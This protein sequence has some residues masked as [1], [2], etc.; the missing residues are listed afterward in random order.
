MLFN[1]LQFLIFFIVVTPAYYLLSSQR[2]RVWLLLIASC[3]F[4]MSFVPKYILILGFTIIIDYLAGLQ[5]AKST[6]RSRKTWL[7]LSLVANIGILVYYKYFMFLLDN[8]GTAL[9]LAHISYE[10]PYLSILLPIGLSFHTFQAMSY[11]IEVYRGKQPP[12]RNFIVYALYV[13]FYP[14]L[15]AGPIE[16]PQNVLHQFH[17]YKEYK[18]DNVKEGLAR[19]LWGFFKKVVIADRLAMVA[20]YTFGYQEHASGWALAVGAIFYSFQIYCDFSGYSDIG[21]GAAKVMGIRLMENFNQP[22]LSSNITTFWSRWHISLS[23]WFRDYVYIPL[24]GNRKGPVRRRINVFIVFLLS[25]L[26]HGA[27]WTFVL[28]GALHGLL[29][30]FF[31]GKNKASYNAPAFRKWLFILLNFVLVTFCWV[32]FRSPNIKAALTYI[33]GIVTMQTGLF[34]LNLHLPELILS[35]ALIVFML[36]RESRNTGFFIRS[37]R[38][39]A[40]YFTSMVIACYMLGIFN[41][42]QFIYFQF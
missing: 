1:S 12:E 37:N 23:S 21:I 29:V 19:M 10:I 3:Y 7:I 27:N 39:F 9:H 33:K 32:F 35:L 28:W 14:Q 20:D 6:G 22:Y 13:M 34:R 8:I 31:P 11:T 41:E 26:W 18:W 15:V 36:W 42:N 24:G 25:G 4:Y 30:T 5:I 40:L 2:A 16:R 38:N 17:E